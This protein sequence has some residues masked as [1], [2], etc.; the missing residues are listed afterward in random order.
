M[1]QPMAPTTVQGAPEGAGQAPVSQGHAGQGQQ[2]QAGAG[3]F[4][5]ELLAFSLMDG[6]AGVL[7]VCGKSVADTKAQR[8]MGG[9]MQV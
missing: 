2:A 3:M 5:E 8:P 1:Q 6:R 4:T 7:A 9:S